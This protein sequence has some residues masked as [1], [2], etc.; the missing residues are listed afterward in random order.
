MTA[1]LR[2]VP[3]D[4]TLTML[5]PIHIGSG[6]E[7]DP[8]EYVVDEERYPDGEPRPMLYVLDMARFFARL[9]DAQ[10]REFD[11]ATRA[12]T[13]AG[14]L[15]LR[16]FIRRH[17]RLDH[18][19]RWKVDCSP[20]IL[21]RYCEGLRNAG[22][23]LRIQL[24]T[25]NPVT[26]CPYVPGSSIK[27]ALRTAWVDRCAAALAAAGRAAP[28]GREF[29]PV[30]LGYAVGTLSG[31]RGEIR[32]DPFRALHVGDAELPPGEC[33]IEPVEIYNP[34]AGRTSNP[35]GIQMYYDVTFSRLFGREVVARG[36]LTAH[37][38]LAA[39]DT[40]GQRGWDF[41]HAVA[42]PVP[43]DEL[44]S[45]CNAFYR[46]RLEDELK[47]FVAKL[48][49]HAAKLQGAADHLRPGEALIRLG[50]FSHCECVTV[51]RTGGPPARLGATRS[52]V[53]GEDPLGWAIL[54]LTPH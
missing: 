44:L 48:G 6:R 50:R 26:G 43:V 41:A 32:A 11:E 2:P 29:E 51:A 31:R 1:T 8:V 21:D 16:N 5:S 7:I 9:S 3:Y 42:G 17:V 52:L 45:A 40:H 37:P 23:Q 22:A 38:E 30:A 33:V 18:D 20:E 39:A 35:E 49:R 4:L 34:K 54:R 53:A 15:A 25:R 24:M 46:P 27:G 28:D 12:S 47:R 13:D 36:R 14:V 10:R 19:A